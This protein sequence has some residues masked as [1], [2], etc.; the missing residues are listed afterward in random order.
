MLGRCELLAISSCTPLDRAHLLGSGGAA[1]AVPSVAAFLSPPRG[2]TAG[3]PWCRNRG[4]GREAC[5]SDSSWTLLEETTGGG[6]TANGVHRS[7]I[8]DHSVRR[9]A[10]A[11]LPRAWPQGDQRTA[12]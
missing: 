2:A 8:R 12:D 9:N 3:C 5:E 10:G 4:M 6:R 7:G 11:R 1:L